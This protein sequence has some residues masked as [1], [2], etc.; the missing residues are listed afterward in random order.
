LL[1]SFL[2][3]P[4]IASGSNGQVIGVLSFG[5]VIARDWASEWWMSSIQLLCGWAAGALPQAKAVLRTNFF[6]ALGCME[7]MDQVAG[8]IVHQLPHVLIDQVR[9]GYD[10][11][12]ME[13]R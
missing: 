2:A 8:L 10:D 7:D 9:P 3:V 4:V 13:Y 5:A 6:D 1:Q 12:M 11:V